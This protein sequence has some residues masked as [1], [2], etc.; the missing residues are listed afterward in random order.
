MSLWI[1]VGLSILIL[2]ILGTTKTEN[3]IN[4]NVSKVLSDIKNNSDI[5]VCKSNIP[6]IP[7]D[8]NKVPNYPKHLEP[9]ETNINNNNYLE[10][11][12]SRLAPKF[13]KYTFMIPELKYDGIYSRKL[14]NNKYYWSK[15]SNKFETY[16]SNN[17]LHKPIKSL[18][19]KTI[20]EPP[21][22]EGYLSGNPPNYYIDD[23]KEKNIPCVINTKL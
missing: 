13:G 20:I 10:V 19:G 17:L 11:P 8:C 22:C 16:G 9:K 4:S 1:I 12:F 2:F 3:F 5:N 14:D 23:C 7:V 18:N 21:E 15:T 6:L